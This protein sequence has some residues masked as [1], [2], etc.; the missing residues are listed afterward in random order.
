[1]KQLIGIAFLTIVSIALVEAGVFINEKIPV[2][3]LFG[4]FYNLL[5]NGLIYLFGAFKTFQLPNNHYKIKAFE[6]QG[7]LYKSFG[8]DFARRIIKFSGAVTFDGKRSSIEQLENSMLFAEK[9]H[10]V[11]FGLNLITMV[12]LMFRGFWELMPSML[13]FNLLLNIYPI[14]AQ[15]YNRARIQLVQN[16]F[17]IK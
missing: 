2:T 1:M 16:R 17:P 3:F 8:V 4:F 10:T 13:L 7:N 14:I 12:Y 9:C 5:I 15:R 6:K 11:C